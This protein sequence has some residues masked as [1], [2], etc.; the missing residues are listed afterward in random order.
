M[1]RP[2]KRVRREKH[3]LHLAVK[4]NKPRDPL[5]WQKVGLGVTITSLCGFLLV[6][7][8]FAAQTAVKRIFV[9]N[10]VF[11]IATIEVENPEGALS[12]SEIL[13]AAGVLPGQSLMAI[14]L[15]ATRERIE[16][17]PAVAGVVVERRL[18]S[19]LKITV[20]ERQ[21]VARLLPVASSGARLAQSIY[22]IDANAHVI[23]PKPGETLKPLPVI[24][25]VPSDAVIEGQRIERSEVV[26]AI[27]FL[28]L[29]DYS[30]IRSELDLNQI[31]VERKG[32]LIVRT[33]NK[34][35]IRFRTDHLSEQMQRLEVILSDAQNRQLVV[36]S[37]DLTPERNVPVTYFR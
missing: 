15:A 9:E 12:R 11:R 7:L 10:E 34:G 13:T 35:S 21:P 36:R 6:G 19:T 28:R 26:S 27:N 16:G 24:T 22:Y 32:Y 37:I 8:G 4:K 1:K 18:P 14:D 29:A 2:I 31:Q 17:L 5:I 33:R 23:K 30:M 3:V 20:T 25:G